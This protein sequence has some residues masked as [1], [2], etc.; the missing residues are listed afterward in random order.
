MEKNLE[1]L[2]RIYDQ[3][4]DDL[5]E[6]EEADDAKSDSSGSVGEIMKAIDTLPTQEIEAIESSLKQKLD[7]VNLA[8]KDSDSSDDFCRTDEPATA[9]KAE[10]LVSKTVCDADHTA[11]TGAGDV[12]DTSAF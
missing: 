7:D 9:Q 12:E 8:R 6:D 4:E 3:I 11:Q 5:K 2:D 1:E 10:L